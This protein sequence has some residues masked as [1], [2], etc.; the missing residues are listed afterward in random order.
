[1]DAAIAMI[2]CTGVVFPHSSGLGGGFFLNFYNRTA[3]RAFIIDARETAPNN[4][5]P[6]M[7]STNN[8]LSEE[9]GLAIAGMC[10]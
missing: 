6:N 1:V 8:L 10:H 4:S 9:G 3:K 5:Y 2:L 7:F